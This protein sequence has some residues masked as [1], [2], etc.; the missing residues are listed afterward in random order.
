LLASGSEAKKARYRLPVEHT[1]YDRIGLN[2]SDVRQADPRLAAAIDRTLGKARSIINVGAGTGSY[3]PTDREVLAVEPSGVMIAQR[4]PGCAD[5]IQA[6][7]EALPLPDKSF[8]AALGVLTLQHWEDIYRGIDELLRVTRER[9]VLV[10]VD[11]AAL[12][13]FWLVADYFPDALRYH[14]Q[15]F[16]AIDELCALLPNTRVERFPVPRDFSDG[17]AIALWGKPEA[18]LDPRVRAVSS[19]WHHMPTNS[20]DRGLGKLCSDL[21]SGQWDQRYGQ[22]RTLEQLDVGVRIVTS[23]VGE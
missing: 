23:E 18:H 8:D 22:L 20:V 3:E 14:G 15:R 5:V 9:I 12:A 21:R 19:V 17:F 2:Y 16:P 1:A 11:T 10:T 6:V 13:D 4:P 7:V